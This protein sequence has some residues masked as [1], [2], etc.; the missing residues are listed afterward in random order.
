MLINSAPI[1]S[2]S[3]ATVE[4]DDMVTAVAGNSS[5]IMPAVTHETHQGILGHDKPA[6]GIARKLSSL[7]PRIY[8]AS[9]TVGPFAY[10]DVNQITASG[11]SR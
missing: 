9:S 10:L 4:R 6:V 11:N 1:A 8:Q 5:P 2:A 7:N 3:G